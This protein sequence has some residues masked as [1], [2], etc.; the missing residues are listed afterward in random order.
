[1]YLEAGYT[2]DKVPCSPKAY[3]RPHSKTHMSAEKLSNCIARIAQ[4]HILGG[5]CVVVDDTKCV[6]YDY[7][8]WNDELSAKVRVQFP[9]CKIT[10]S[11]LEA[12]IT[13]FVVIFTIYER[14]N[15]A[16]ECMYVLLMICVM[17]VI[18][19]TLFITVQETLPLAPTYLLSTF[20]KLYAKT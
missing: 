13:G 18:F 6:L 3:N 11:S 16:L 9:T 20:N 10:V 1:M 5:K 2:Q 8:E 14:R 12:S 15:T 19:R 17:G 4:L 7:A